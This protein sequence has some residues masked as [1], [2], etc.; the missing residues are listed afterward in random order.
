MPAKPGRSGGIFIFV[1]S[2]AAISLAIP[3]IDKRSG[4]FG[5]ISNS[6]ITSSFVLIIFLCL[7]PL[8]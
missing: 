7:G 3:M 2:I 5:V 1:F 4:R 6:K 8:P